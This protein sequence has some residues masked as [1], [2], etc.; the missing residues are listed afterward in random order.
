MS[1][2]SAPQT[3]QHITSSPG[4]CGGKPSIIGTRIR[5][6][7]VA[8]L[9]RS[10]SSPGEIVS[11]YPSLTLA[12]VHAALSFYYDNQEALDQAAADDDRFAAELRAKLGPGPL[13][14]KLADQAAQ[15][16]N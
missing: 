16:S 9:A 5:V 10:G 14:Q 7:D 11:Y 4:V 6:M 12:D 8:S 13:E 3:R 15:T 1:T 2:L